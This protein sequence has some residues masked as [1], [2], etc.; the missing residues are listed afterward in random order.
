MEL[1]KD[2]TLMESQRRADLEVGYAIDA[3]N[4]V[5][6][7]WKK[8]QRRR[9][10]ANIVTTSINKLTTIDPAT[11]DHVHD[12][13]K[14]KMAV[15]IMRC[16]DIPPWMDVENKRITYRRLFPIINKLQ[17][18]SPNTGTG[19]SLSDVITTRLSAAISHAA[20]DPKEQNVFVA[21]EPQINRKY[22]RYIFGDEQ[23]EH[24]AKMQT[25][26]LPEDFDTL[27]NIIKIN[28]RKACEKYNGKKEEPHNG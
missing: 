18:I 21:Y 4:D 8:R 28:H 20:E 19:G 9:N 6:N 26:S 24:V 10:A 17:R 1:I 3:I 16:M 22:M 15:V 5:Y 23:P 27:I 13:A 14:T 7:E 12:A 2:L 11:V 25:L